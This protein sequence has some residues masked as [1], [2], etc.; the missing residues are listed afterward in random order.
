MAW[1]DFPEHFALLAAQEDMTV[2]LTPRSADSLGLA[3]VEL[4]PEG[5]V[6]EECHYGEGDY[7]FDFV[8]HAVRKAHR[9]YRV[10]RPW[11]EFDAAEARTNGDNER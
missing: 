4:T 8:V 11:S 7:D 10:V 2:T 5:M 9:D 1:V 6:V 3:V